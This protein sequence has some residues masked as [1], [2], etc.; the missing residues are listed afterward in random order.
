MPP[1]QKESYS[2]Q[3]VDNA[4]DVLEALCEEGEEVRISQL[5][6]RLGMN[7]TSIFRL[8]ATFENR[9]YVEKE[10]RSGKYKL[11]IS[12]Y[13]MGQKFLSCMGLLRNAKPVIERLARECNEALYLAVPRGNEI[14]MLDMV[15]TLQQVKIIPLVGNRYPV[16]TVS[17]GLVIL[18][19][20]EAH[21]RNCNCEEL[22]AIS[23][24]LP[25]ILKNGGY[26]D[27]GVMGEGITSLSVPIIDAQG[28]VPGSLCMVGPEFRLTPKKIKETYLPQLIEAGVVISSKLGYVGHFIS[29]DSYR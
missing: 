19:N 23:V 3:S 14:L 29:K 28:N 20:S 4:L 2:I 10:P 12:A 22:S 16:T 17:A 24:T 27:R 21:R 11:G 6:E 5:S 1:R 9:G 7:K 8:L 15:D 26:I 13:E 25:E 18:A